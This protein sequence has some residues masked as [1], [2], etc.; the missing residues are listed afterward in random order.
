MKF[1]SVI[2]ILFSLT[3]NLCSAQHQYYNLGEYSHTINFP[4]H[5]VSFHVLISERSMSGFDA[6][7][8]YSWYS[9]NQI[10][11]TQGGF[12]GKL[13]HGTYSDHYTSKNL[14]ELG[15]FDRGLKIGLWRA[16]QEDG[17]L[18]SSLR[19]REGMLNGP[20]QKYDK[21]GALSEEGRY[22]NGLLNG[23][24]KKYSG[25]DGLQVVRYRHGKIVA[26]KPGKIARWVK[27]FFA[28]K[29]KNRNQNKV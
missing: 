19:Y 4:D 14:K 7:K 23:K 17:I 18:I 24:L 3:V 20:F 6:D 1:L 15:E 28:K 25:T 8:K 13:L 12:A 21:A 26:D 10:N 11:I 5:K 2:A 27:A 9:G 29:V 16:W 22:V